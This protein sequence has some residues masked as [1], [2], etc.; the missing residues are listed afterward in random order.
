MTVRALGYVGVSAPD[1]ADWRTYGTRH[2]GLQLV[3]RAEGSV[4]FRMDDRAQRLVVEADGNQHDSSRGVKFI[5]WEAAD[6][7][8]LEAIAARVEGAGIRVERAS[9]ALAQERRVKD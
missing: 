8:A 7:A 4:A 9:Q 1:L 6:A 2:L 3:D 5:G